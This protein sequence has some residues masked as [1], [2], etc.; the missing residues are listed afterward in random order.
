MYEL[1]SC[2]FCKGENINAVDCGTGV[3]SANSYV[4]CKDCHAVIFGETYEK[5]IAA[6]NQRAER[7]CTRGEEFW[8]CSECGLHGLH[9]D[10]RYCPNCG[11]KVVGD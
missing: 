10:W 3:F 4:E 1:K 7:T 11:V 9:S 2:P 5:A 8:E 6:W